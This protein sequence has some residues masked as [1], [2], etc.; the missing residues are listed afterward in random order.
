MINQTLNHLPGWHGSHSWLGGGES[1]VFL[2]SNS[3]VCQLTALIPMSDRSGNLE[4]SKRFKGKSPRNWKNKIKTCLSLCTLSQTNACIF[5]ALLEREYQCK[6]KSSIIQTAESTSTR[7]KCCLNWWLIDV[8]FF[9]LWIVIKCIINSKTYAA[10]Y[11][12]D[13]Y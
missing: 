12:K 6:T 13:L 2:I 4:I 8:Q 10:C 9:K 11:F 7:I 3:L 5:N 1:A